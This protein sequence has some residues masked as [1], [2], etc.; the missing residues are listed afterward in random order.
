MPISSLPLLAF[1]LHFIP[2]FALYLPSAIKFICSAMLIYGTVYNS[3]K[4]DLQEAAAARK[5]RKR[6]DDGAAV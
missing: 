2:A 6:H 5:E 3:P 1:C 4:I